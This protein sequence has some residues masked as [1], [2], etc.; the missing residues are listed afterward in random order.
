MYF[1]AL[2][3]KDMKIYHL[4]ICCFVLSSVGN[5]AYS[6]ELRSD[7]SNIRTD[8]VEQSASPEWYKKIKIRGYTQ[9]RYNRL[10][11]TNADLTCD[12]CDKSW[13]GNGGFFLRRIRL[14]FYGKITDRLSFYLQP[15][16]ASSVD[17]SNSN[18]AQLKDAY[19]DLG[20]DKENEFRLR[21]GQSKIP[22]GFENLQSSQNRLPLD[23]ADGTNSSISNERDLGVLFY[24]APKKIRERFSEIGNARFKGSGDYGVFAFGIF[25]G[26][27]ANKN[28]ANDQ[29]HIVSR[30]TYP[31]ELKNKQIIEPSLQF[32]TGKYVLP[33]VSSGVIANNNFQYRDQRAAASFVL[34][35]QP[36]GL[37]MEYNMGTGPQ[38]NPITNTIEQHRLNGGYALVSYAFTIKKQLLLPFARY[39]YYNGGKK[40]ERDARNYVVKDLEFGAEWQASKYLEFVTVYTI[41]DRRFE[42]S[43][44][45]L[46]HQEGSLLRLQLQFNY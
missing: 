5:I 30:F 29:P 39:Q 45:P 33:T 21:F 35:P 9:L 14:V 22:F 3:L 1:R 24:W 6:Q 31:F 13:G 28:D 4:V 20:L 19:F 8:S 37:Q 41:S 46:N 18:F 27:T 40:H 26:Q 42:D 38:Y 23:R 10:L 15:D 17:A 2:L 12:Q 34:Y 7:T 32:Y 11:E 16:F 43:L 36:F 25:N 44:K